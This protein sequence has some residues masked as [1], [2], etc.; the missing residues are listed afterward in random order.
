MHDDVLIFRVLLFEPW[1]VASSI[2]VA[3]ELVRD[4]EPRP[5][6]RPMQFELA[7]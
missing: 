6:P 2:D 3:W 7:V 1:A 4:E 5:Y